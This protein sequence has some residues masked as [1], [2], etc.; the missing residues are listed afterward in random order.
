VRIVLCTQTRQTV[1]ILTEFYNIIASCILLEGSRRVGV[2]LQVLQHVGLRGQGGV[3]RRIWPGETHRQVT[4]TVKKQSEQR[5]QNKVIRKRA[6]L[7]ERPPVL[8][9]SVTL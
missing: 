7:L 8:G 1:L 4:I 5:A 6:N 3:A 2:A 9:A